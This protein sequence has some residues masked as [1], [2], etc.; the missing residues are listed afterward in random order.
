MNTQRTAIAEHLKAGN[1]I[2][3]LEAAADFG[4][5]RLAAVVWTLRKEGMNI[6][7]EMVK[8][9]TRYGTSFIARYSL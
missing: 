7:T 5:T 9:P 6:K 4:C 1:S 2:T 3:Q 8:V